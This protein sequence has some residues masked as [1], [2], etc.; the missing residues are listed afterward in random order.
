VVGIGV[1]LTT[2]GPPQAGGIS[3][4]SATGVTVT[5]E[6]LLDDVLAFLEGEWLSASAWEGSLRDS[7]RRH[8]VTVGQ[9]ITAEGP[10]GL[11][12]GVAINIDDEGCL[13]VDNESGRFS[14]TAGDVRHVRTP[15]GERI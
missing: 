15:T 4:R 14:I 8:C 11:I 7:F 12:E 1:N 6:A 13:L 3:I 10:R 9:R 2:D 5:P